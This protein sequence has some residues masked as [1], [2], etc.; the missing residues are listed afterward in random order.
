MLARCLSYKLDHSALPHHRPLPVY[1]GEEPEKDESE[2]EDGD[3][4]EEEG[5]GD[6]DDEEEDDDDDAGFDGG[7]GDDAP[8]DNKSRTSNASSR[9]QRQQAMMTL[10][11]KARLASN[12]L[13][14]NGPEL[15]HIITT[16]QLKSKTPGAI[17]SN[18][19][20]KDGK[21]GGGYVHDTMEIVIDELD[22][23]I[24][25]QISKYA[26]EKAST[27]KR[28]VITNAAV[29]AAAGATTPGGV[30][31]FNNSSNNAGPERKRR[32]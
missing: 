32:K 31:A 18:L 21:N 20:N 23:N 3:N 15:G 11:A 22:P 30:G 16:I 29:A 10:D 12:L 14:L 5:S 17:V 25:E 6:D 13:V 27:R 2:E 9:N 1:V 8:G 24:F 19:D 28:S 7:S 4:D 26:A